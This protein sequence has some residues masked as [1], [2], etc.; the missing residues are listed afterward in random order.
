MTKLV[1]EDIKRKIIEMYE[2]TLDKPGM[3]QQ[4]IAKEL[5][6]SQSVISYNLREYK[7]REFYKVQKQ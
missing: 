1:T 2:G 4:D 7:L 3:K 5:G 6:M